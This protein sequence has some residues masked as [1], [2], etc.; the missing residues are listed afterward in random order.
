MATSF[1]NEPTTF[2]SVSI[3]RQSVIVIESSGISVESRQRL[4][5]KKHR[6]YTNQLA[7]SVSTLPEAV[8][9]STVADSYI[10]YTENLGIISNQTDWFLTKFP[11]LNPAAVRLHK[12]SYKIDSRTLH[13]TFKLLA[14]LFQVAQKNGLWW[15]LPLINVGFSSEVLLEWWHNSRKLDFDILGSNIDYMKVWGADID[16]EMEDGSV[17]IIEYDL[18]SLWKWIS[19]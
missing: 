4:I 18:I 1:L 16:D 2:E 3:A 11:E 12:L 6:K 14:K 19:N 13:T 15:D 9:K 5:G 10:T 7:V 17:A 8:Y